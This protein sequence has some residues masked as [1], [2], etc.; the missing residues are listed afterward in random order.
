MAQTTTKSMG[1]Q[2]KKTN[3][4]AHIHKYPESKEG[5]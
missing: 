2:M 1:P 5:F 4:W 3:I